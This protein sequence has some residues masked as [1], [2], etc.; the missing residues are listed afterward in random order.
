MLVED[1]LY[2]RFWAG[3]RD[4]K[5]MNPFGALLLEIRDESREAAYPAKSGSEPAVSVVRR[6]LFTLGGWFGLLNLIVKSL[7]VFGPVRHLRQPR[8]E[9]TG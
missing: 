1:S 8:G 4:R 9:L 7:R 2:A 6:N 5:G 3:G